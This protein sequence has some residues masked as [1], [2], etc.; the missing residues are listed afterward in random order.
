MTKRC[1][2]PTA[3]MRRRCC[4][5]AVIRACGLTS[6]SV[7]ADAQ[8]SP[9]AS[10]SPAG[11]RVRRSRGH[12][13]RVS[14]APSP[15][16]AEIVIAID[17]V[18]R[19]QHFGLLSP[20]RLVVDLARARLDFANLAYDGLRR[21]PVTGVRIS[22]YRADTVRLVIDVDG[23]LKYTASR[24]GTELRLLVKGP[25]TTFAKWESSVAPAPTAPASVAPAPKATAPTTP[26]SR[27][28][29]TSARPTRGAVTALSVEP[30][31][32]GAQLDIAID[33][34]IGVSHFRIPLPWRVVIDLSG[35]RLDAALLYDGVIRGAIRN[36]RA[37]QYRADT[38]RLVI[39]LDER[40]NYTVSRVG[41]QLRVLVSGASGGFDR[42]QSTTTVAANTRVADSNTRR[43]RSPSR[44]RTAVAPASMSPPATTTTSLNLATP[45]STTTTKTPEPAVRRIERTEAIS[46]VAFGSISSVRQLPDGRVLVNDGARRRLVLLDSALSNPTVVLDSFAEVRNAYGR[47]AGTLITDVRGATLF[48]DPASLAVLVLD[49]TAKVARVRSVPSR[50]G[51]MN[52]ITNERNGVPGVDAKGRFVY[53]IGAAIE[54]PAV[55]P[56]ANQSY[57]PD[58]P[59][60]A[61]VIGVQFDSRVFDTLGVVRVPKFLHSSRLEPEGYY[62][63]EYVPHPMP[64]T[65]DWAVLSDGTVAFVRG[66]DYRVE[67]RAPDGTVTSSEKLPFPWVRL[68]DDDKRQFADSVNTQ[69]VM[70][71]RREYTSLVIAWSN[72][73]NKPY[74][75]T[76]SAAEGYAPPPG[77]P[78]DWILPKGVQFPANYVAT[79]PPGVYAPQD[80]FVEI[81]A[82]ARSLAVL[83]HE[84]LCAVSRF[85]DA[86]GTGYAPPPPTYRSPTLVKASDLPDYRPPFA[87][88]AARADDDGNLWVRPLPMGSPSSV[89][90]FDVIS[91][92]GQLIDRVQLPTGFQLV[93]F[94]KGGVL[95][96]R[97]RD[98]TGEHLTKVRRR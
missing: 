6:L 60:S 95:Y 42:W 59:D 16:G 89:Q 13:S 30:T 65:D 76:F 85:V 78:R 51:D 3:M 11:A 97:N 84:R 18:V 17:S 10:S 94:G 52:L 62:S 80:Q 90:S 46:S 31:A 81:P 1:L 8:T 72:L 49:S 23:A 5:L 58:V 71:A 36:V 40:H 15:N 20:R 45:P 35:A 69:A 96:L 55:A 61:F 14:I 12:V 25:S 73:L 70:N 68:S 21:G 27:A 38:V 4:L 24:D 32:D 28:A 48:V 75:A 22:Q 93:G 56:P 34:T 44:S 79:C 63:V 39:D 53:R 77:L 67:F 29:R 19:E 86:Y 98:D 37:S 7:V 83:A 91:R 2:H 74:P 26:I 54:R 9:V 41:E 47:R 87:E 64:L 66:Q 50:V 57:E 43:P 82:N 33:S 88:G 92:Q